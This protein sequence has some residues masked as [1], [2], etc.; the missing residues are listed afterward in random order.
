MPRWLTGWCR[1]V[2]D[3]RL[4]AILFTLAT[5]L[6]LMSLIP[7]FQSP[8]EPAHIAR[9]YLL[10]KGQIVLDAPPAS[11]SGGQVD[12]GL[13][14]FAASYDMLRFAPD[15]KLTQ[16]ERLSSEQIR[17]AGKERFE[18]VPGTG[19]YFPLAYLPQSLALFIGKATGLSVAQSYFLARFFSLGFSVLVIALAFRTFPANLFS[20]ALLILPMSIFQFVSASLDGFTVALGVLAVSL[21]MRGC[22][23]ESDYDYPP[24]MS[25]AL[26]AAILVLATSR[27][28]LLPL[29][30]MPL[31]VFAM[32]RNARDVWIFLGVALLVLAWTVLA[33]KTTQLSRP[34]RPPSSQIVLHYLSHPL[35]FF[36]V[37]RNTLGNGP[38]SKSYL[39]SFIGVLGWL[40][41]PLPGWFYRT[42]AAL[43]G[44]MAVLSLSLRRI[45]ACWLPPAM[46]AMMSLGSILL[47]FLALLI[48]WS[49]HPATVIEGVQ[50]RYF[51]I[52]LILLGY[53]LYG[54]GPAAV[55]TWKYGAPLLVAYL[56]LVLWV[57]PDTLV[58]RYFMA[59]NP[60][61]AVVAGRSVLPDTAPCLRPPAPP[62]SALA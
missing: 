38:L 44:I 47:T 39:T 35:A 34:A 22:S 14:A 52:P 40:D 23:R 41:T 26:G 28:N 32:R 36:D 9:A 49:P 43:L 8:D 25:Y 4:A 15:R 21:F 48:G 45:K 60:P 20:F 11:D 29:L 31:V 27:T 59:A 37:L 1:Y 61:H 51:T 54:T 13:L 57:L 2:A 30:A 10:T 53:A 24:W 33:F 17:W 7:P 19:Y 62:L 5:G 50:G 55:R 12:E 58:K 46:L 16:R 42:T 56:G 18:S 6:V 3:R